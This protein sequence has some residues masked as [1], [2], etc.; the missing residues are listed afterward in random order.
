MAIS[1]SAQKEK[2]KYL[3]SVLLSLSDSSSKKGV[4]SLS[5]VARALYLK[6]TTKTSWRKLPLSE[7]YKTH[8]AFGYWYKKLR[9][10]GKFQEVKKVISNGDST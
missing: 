1:K 7:H 6:I 8:T 5:E 3:H 4:Y 9:D 2:I 10:S